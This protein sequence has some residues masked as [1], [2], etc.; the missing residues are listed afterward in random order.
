MAVYYQ[1]GY[2]PIKCKCGK[3]DCN[4][5]L[6]IDCRPDKVISGCNN[7]TGASGVAVVAVGE[8]VTPRNI[9]SLSLSGLRCLK[10]PSI[11]LDL[12]AIVTVNAA[13]AVDTV[14]TFRIFKRCGNEVEREIQSFDVS[15]GLAL[16]AGASIPVAFSIC[17]HEDCES[18]CCTYRVTVEATATEAVASAININQGTIFA[19]ATDLC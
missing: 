19:I 3:H 1:P 9:G 4:C 13:L 6:E 12:T 15:F 10:R 2:K 8:T 7:L 18:N 11:K 5:H 14:I 16:I 17:D